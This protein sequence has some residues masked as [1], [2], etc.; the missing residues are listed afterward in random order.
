MTEE[1]TNLPDNALVMHSKCPDWGHG[2]LAWKRDSK[3]AYHFED[4]KLRVFK[5]EYCH[6]LQEVDLPLDKAQRVLDRLD[7]ALGRHEAATKSGVKRSD[8]LSLD[9]QI[10]IFARMYPDGFGGDDWTEKMRG[11]GA[12]SSLKRHRAPAIAFAQEKLSAE[13]LG[14]IVA[15]QRFDEGVDLVLSV[16]GTT[17][18]VR[19]AQLKPIKGL[20]PH[21]ISGFVQAVL[22]RLHGEGEPAQLVDELVRSMDGPCWELATALA[23]LMNPDEH[24]CVHPTRFKQQAMW[25]AP[26][27]EH[28]K[29]PNGDGYHRYL[30]M[31]QGVRDRLRK[32]GLTPRDL[33]DVYDFMLTT[34]TPSARKMLIKEE[35]K[36]KN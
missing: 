18:L 11:E 5:E 35:K 3:R 28:S 32:A 36:D 21:R 25:M 6:L 13:N 12:K 24:V 26:R 19:P 14:A 33:L 31:V 8:L 7:R 20:A 1:E 29:V 2:L 15:E 27:L 4:G 22:N 23:A 16:L 9:Q 10:E 30:A 34:L 17:N